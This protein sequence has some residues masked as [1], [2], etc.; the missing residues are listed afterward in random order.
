MRVPPEAGSAFRQ[1]MSAPIR[2]AE[3]SQPRSRQD[4]V[5]GCAL[6]AIVLLLALPLLLPLYLVLNFTLQTVHVL[7]SAMEPTVRSGDYLVADRL[8]YRLHAPGRGDVVNLRDPSDPGRDLIKRVVGLPGERVLVSGCAVFVNGRRLAEPYVRGWSDCDSP[9]PAG[10]QPGLLGSDEF[11]LMGDNR[12]Y[13]R[14][15]RQLGP[16]RRSQ[17]EAR[18]RVRL[19]PLGRR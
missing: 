17:I 8:V 16:I 15:S 19:L 11:F 3:P 2:P 10:G 18:V 13:S 14:D 12:D 6:A 9:W 1:A 4:W 5:A 7:G